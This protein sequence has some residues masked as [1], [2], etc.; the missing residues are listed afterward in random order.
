MAVMKF[1][2]V[3]LDAKRRPALPAHLLEEVGM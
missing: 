2:Q 1:T 3:K